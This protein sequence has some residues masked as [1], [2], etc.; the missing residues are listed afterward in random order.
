[1]FN[2]TLTI[3]CTCFFSHLI[4]CTSPYENLFKMFL[5]GISTQ[6]IPS[7]QICRKSSVEECFFDD[8]AL[9]IECQ[10]NKNSLFQRYF[11]AILP[12]GLPSYRISQCNIVIFFYHILK[13]G[14]REVKQMRKREQ[15]II[16]SSFPCCYDFNMR[17]FLLLKRLWYKKVIRRT[18]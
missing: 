1:M 14:I 9:H 13:E 11:L 10:F 12:A 16:K 2:I 7:R 4:T 8:M 17:K 3:P 15:T 18:S 5:S 6:T